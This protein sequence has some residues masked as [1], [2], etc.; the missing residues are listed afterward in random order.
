MTIAAGKPS[1]RALGWAGRAV[2]WWLGELGALWGDVARRFAFE[3]RNAIVIEA[4]ERYWLLRHRQRPLGQI[5]RSALEMDEMRAILARVAPEA[6]SRPILV[7]I[8]HERVLTKRITLPAVAQPELERILRFEIARHF[9]FPAERVHFRHRILARGGGTIEIEIVAVARETV[10][11]ICAALDAAGLAASGIRLAGATGAA[12]LAL[13]RAVLGRSAT[14]LKRGD[15]ALLAAL[16]VLALAAIASP[17]VHDR[18]AL[19]SVERDIDA[20]RPQAQAMLD[21]RQKQADASARTAG[22]LRLEAARPPL[23]SVLD[24]LTKAVPDGAWL[25]SLN[26]SGTEIVIDGLAPSAATVALALEQSGVFAGVSF[27]SPIARDPGT[28]LERFELAAS[29][30]APKP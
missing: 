24:A 21:A 11:E 13:P 20:V 25:Q 3:R 6:R 15:R 8:P 27:R 2:A 17:I 5:D 26:V 4:G 12:P 16:G 23:V 22:P 28:G 10:A 18:L 14:R 1:K 19:A 7:E 30:S 9:P 29:I